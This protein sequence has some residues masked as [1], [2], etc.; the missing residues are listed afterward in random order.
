M[1]GATA[2]TDTIQQLNHPTDRH[3][4]ND[5]LERQHYLIVGQGLAGSLTALALLDRGCRVSVVDAAAETAASRITGGLA[6]PL[7]GPRLTFPAAGEAGVVHSWQRYRELEKHF[8]CTILSRFTLLHNIFN[9]EEIPRYR[10]R[11]TQ[12]S[13]RQWLGDFHQPGS[14]AGILTDPLG[15]FEIHGG[16]LEAPALLDATAQLLRGKGALYREQLDPRQLSIDADG[17]HW[18]GQEFTQVI[19]C[20]GPS[21][22][23][24]P[25]LT[26]I[27]ITTIP[28]EVL[29]LAPQEPLPRY[30]FHAAGAWMAP[31][32]NGEAKLGSTYGTAN[33]SAQVTDTAREAL[34][35]QLPRLLARPPAYTLS[36]HQAG[37]RPATPS[38]Q[39][40]L[41]QLPGQPIALL[42][43]LGSR[44]VLQAPY[45]ADAL[46]EHLLAGSPIPPGCLSPQPA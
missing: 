10:K 25:W 44:A 5:K 15:S 28:G 36:D 14:Y 1:N 34:L 46:A 18:R 26:G 42:N 22:R 9:R 20:D 19:F 43:G 6:T 17:V 30:I 39:P 12:E 11:L 35:N 23:D 31:L 13:Y 37:L 38:K 29:T 40:I 32:P 2:I 16:H 8:G 7:A 24:N 27:D 21:A 45:L 3:K 33:T 41:G 4:G